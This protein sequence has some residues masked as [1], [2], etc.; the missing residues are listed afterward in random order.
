MNWHWVKILLLFTTLFSIA[1]YTHTHTIGW[2]LD[3]KGDEHSGKAAVVHRVESHVRKMF[4]RFVVNDYL[5]G[6]RERMLKVEHFQIS[7][8]EMM[9]YVKYCRLPILKQGRWDNRRSSE[10]ERESMKMR[11]ASTWSSNRERGKKSR[12]GFGHSQYFENATKPTGWVPLH[13]IHTM[14]EHHRI[15]DNFITCSKNVLILRRSRSQR[16]HRQQ[17]TPNPSV[18]NVGN[19]ENAF[20]H[21]CRIDHISMCQG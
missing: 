13:N 10:R 1:L 2:M 14:T 20:Y 21:V 15:F 3:M 8:L 18:T 19:D 5:N 12:Y 6:L 7:I 16:Q 11:E 9:Q 17:N 4:S